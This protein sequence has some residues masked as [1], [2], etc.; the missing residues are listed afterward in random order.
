[1]RK[2]TLTLLILAILPLLAACQEEKEHA[3]DVVSL[4]T[5]KVRTHTAEVRQ[6]LL[7]TEIVGTVQAMDQAVIAAKITGTIIK[8][9]VVLGSR[10]EAGD[11]LVSISAEEIS[12]KVIQ[13]QAQLEQAR[14]NLERER[15][16]LKKNAATAENV[17]SLEDIFRIS[18][19]AYREAQTMLGYSTITAP[20]DGVISAKTANVG[21]LATPGTPLVRLENMDKLQVVTSVPESLV[22]QVTGG[23]SLTVTIPS[24]NLV[25]T[26]TVAEV[27]PAA[28]Q[29]SRTAKVKI[30]LEK[31]ELIRPGQFAR[32]AIPGKSRG[33]IFIPTAAVR[34]LGQIEQVFVI[35]DGKVDLRLVR[36]GAIIDDQVEILAGLDAG[37]VIGINVSGARLIDGQPVTVVQ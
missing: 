10:V 4:P 16:L 25:T 14:R 30:D 27:A 37:E 18:E 2:T 28:D 20:F 31:H 17:K 1:M 9:P 33:S 34:T 12:A 13:A 6:G 15:K 24:A 23:D 5:A 26:G 36:T 19:A 8:M 3:S 35:R 32:V 29:L 22:L 7:Q 21:D 11:L